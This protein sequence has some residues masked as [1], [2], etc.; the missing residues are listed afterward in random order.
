[1]KTLLVSV[2]LYTG[3]G[4]SAV[5]LSFWVS[6]MWM[7]PSLAQNSA[8]ALPPLPTFQDSTNSPSADNPAGQAP[9]GADQGLVPQSTAD[10]VTS[11]ESLLEPF[12]Y[13]PKGRRDP[14]RVYT[15]LR[16]VEEGDLQVPLFPLQRFELD[17]L[18]LIGIIWDV[19]DPKAMFLD[20]NSEVYTVGK[21]ERIGRKNGYIASI[22]EGEIVVIESSRVRGE[23]IYSTRIVRMSR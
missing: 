8:E 2:L 22:R 10:L 15:E 19:N 21:D 5:A 12:I 11:V 7:R 23:M 9:T 1:M 4:I 17:Q 16:Q 6:S 18:R 14:F 3:V 20:P 13:D